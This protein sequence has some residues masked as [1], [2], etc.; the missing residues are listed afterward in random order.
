M[1]ARPSDDPVLLRWT[2]QVPVTDLRDPLGLTLRVAGRLSG[3]LLHGITSLTRPP[4]ITPSCPGASGIT[5]G[6]KGDR[7]LTAA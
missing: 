5:D 7:R 4:G 6:V 1:A 2:K 3:Q